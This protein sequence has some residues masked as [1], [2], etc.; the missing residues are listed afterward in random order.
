[1]KRRTALALPAV[2]ALPAAAQA[3]AKLA[4]LELRYFY[5]RNTKD[6]MSTRLNEFLKSA[7][8][9]ASQRAGATASAY[10]GANLAVSAPYVLAV[11][12]WPSL[13]AYEQGLAKLEADPAYVLAWATATVDRGLLFTRMETQLLRAFKG[14]PDLVVQAAARARVFELRTYQSN[15]PQTLIRKVN[16]FNDGEIAVFRKTGLDPVFFGEMIVGPNQPCL[17]YMLA[18]ESF[19]AREA[20]WEKF[21]AHPEWLKLRAQPGLSDGEIVSNITS[22]FLRPLPFS[23]VR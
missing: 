1:M 19:A 22:C 16:M 15:D 12:S 3:P 14:V 23:P 20:N 8:A 2:A 18:Y 11:R 4:I 6:N 17:V 13:A 5:L 10:F 21:I 9:P 7:D